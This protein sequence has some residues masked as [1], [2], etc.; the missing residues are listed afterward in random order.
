MVRV[1][2]GPRV[3]EVV[4]VEVEEDP[5]GGLVVEVVPDVVGALDGLD[6]VVVVADVPGLPGGPGGPVTVGKVNWGGVE[7]RAE[8]IPWSFRI[9]SV[10][11]SRASAARSRRSRVRRSSVAADRRSLFAVRE[12]R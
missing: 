2:I 8:M 3:V 4:D 10:R 12:S 11:T 5:E 9:S 6:V 7:P 1:T